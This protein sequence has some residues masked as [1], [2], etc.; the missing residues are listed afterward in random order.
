MIFAFFKIERDKRLHRYSLQGRCL[1]V[2]FLFQLAAVSSEASDIRG[3]LAEARVMADQVHII[4]GSPRN[5]RLFLVTAQM[6]PFTEYDNRNEITPKHFD[7]TS[8]LWDLSH[9][10][11][12]YFSHADSQNAFNHRYFTTMT[13]PIS[14]LDLFKF[15]Y[16]LVDRLLRP[17][18]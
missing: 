9:S 12:S 6:L 2:S 14:P 10:G 17:W 8:I 1:V 13:L 11:H 16:P 18:Q 5:R 3:Q 4:T 7:D 15:T